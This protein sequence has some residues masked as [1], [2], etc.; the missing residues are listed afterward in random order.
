MTTLQSHIVRRLLV[1]F[2]TDPGL[3]AAQLPDRLIAD[4][5]GGFAMVGICAISLRSI[6]PPGVP[7]RVGLSTDNVAQR[8][9]VRDADTGERGVYVARRDT[10][11]RIAASLAATIFPARLGHS[12]VTVIDDVER[13]NLVSRP[14]RPGAELDL[15]VSAADGLG[16]DS[17]FDGVDT[18]ANWLRDAAVGWTFEG[19]R[20]ERVTLDTG[21]WPVT[22]LRIEHVR[23]Q[24]HHD[25]FRAS[26]EFDHALIVRDLH[27]RW[28]GTSMP[29]DYAA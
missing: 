29:S 8:I 4:E 28:H 15:V 18:A 3:V 23:S 13:V 1:N 7:T 17:V 5:V 20:V 26:L 25:R 19:D 6:R 11:S 2:R 24:W 27:A 14:N 9:A 12:Q 16:A 21:R 22:P 10:S